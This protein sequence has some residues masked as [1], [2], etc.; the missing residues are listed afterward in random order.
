MEILISQASK[1]HLEFPDIQKEWSFENNK[2]NTM[3]TF[4]KFVQK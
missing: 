1:E 2:Y 3:G 4:A